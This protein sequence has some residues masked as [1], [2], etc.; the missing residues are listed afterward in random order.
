M[1][2]EKKLTI[3]MLNEKKTGGGRGWVLGWD[4]ERRFGLSRHRRNQK[5][6]KHHY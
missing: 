4:E 3:K 2:G 5:R 6:M 1:K